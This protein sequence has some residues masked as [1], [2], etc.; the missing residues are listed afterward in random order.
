[1]CCNISK[2]CFEAPHWETS[3][4]PDKPSRGITGEVCKSAKFDCIPPPELNYFCALCDVP[5]SDVMKLKRETMDNLFSLFITF[6]GLKFV[7]ML[8]SCWRC[9]AQPDFLNV[10]SGPIECVIEK[11]WSIV[12]EIL[13]HYVGQCLPPPLSKCYGTIAV[14]R[15]EFILASVQRLAQLLTWSSEV[16]VAGG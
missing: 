1:M 3:D 14:D 13:E 15:M 12:R 11:P 10:K 6:V 9:L 8:T 4:F 16:V 2:Q 5:A 7:T